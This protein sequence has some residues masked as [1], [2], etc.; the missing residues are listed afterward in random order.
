M[1]PPLLPPTPESN[2]ILCRLPSTPRKSLLISGTV[3][4]LGQRKSISQTIDLRINILLFSQMPHLTA[5]VY[6][7]THQNSIKSKTEPSR[8]LIMFYV[9]YNF[10]LLLLSLPSSSFLLT[11]DCFHVMSLCRDDSRKASMCLHF[12]TLVKNNPLKGP[13]TFMYAEHLK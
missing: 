4:H 11:S 8:S 3:T 10:V 7:S 1:T 13:F 2:L 9:V 6:I 5:I 12:P